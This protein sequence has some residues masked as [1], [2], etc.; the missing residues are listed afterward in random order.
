MPMLLVWSLLGCQE[1]FGADRHDL[2]GFRV[3]SLTAQVDGEQVRPRVAMIVEGRAWSAEPVQLD[4]AFIEEP[5]DSVQ[6]PDPVASGADVVL[7]RTTDRLALHAWTATSSTWAELDLVDRS[8]LALQLSVERTT[9]QVQGL[10]VEQLTREARADW[11]SEPERAVDPGGFLRLTVSGAPQS[12]LGRFMATGDGTWF[13]LEGDVADWAAAEVLI[14][15]EDIAVEPNE[16]GTHTVLVASI[17]TTSSGFVATDVHIGE[18]PQ[19][20]YVQG[21]FLPGPTS[22]AG[23]TWITLQAD[24]SAP[25]G[26]AF[27]EPAAAEPDASWS[28]E[29]LGCVGV[30]GPF[31][32][33]W[34]LQARCGRDAL[35]GERVLVEVDP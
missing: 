22:A 35:V 3:A 34:L 17:D 33:D 8:E 4:W 25:S 18:A 23:R 20:I 21:R 19:G 9:E 32:P 15:D 13:E 5:G 24:D 6:E 11:T 30:Q 14:D 7:E 26:L 29:A 27:T 28:G 12:A 16:P 2:R 31:D 1:P 10:T